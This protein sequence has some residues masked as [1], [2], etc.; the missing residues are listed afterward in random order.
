MKTFKQ[1]LFF[2]FIFLWSQSVFSLMDNHESLEK[3]LEQSL[4]VNWGVDRQ[5]N[6]FIRNKFKPLLKDASHHA[7]IKNFIFLSKKQNIIFPADKEIRALQPEDGIFK[8]TQEHK[9]VFENPYVR[10]LLGSTEPGARENFHT[11]VWK[12][13]MVVIIPTTYEIEY[14]DGK[15]EKIVYPIGV[16]E[17]PAG[18]CY[19]CTNLGNKAD[20]S[21]RFEIKD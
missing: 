8:A 18:E 19:A 15:K 7:I 12:S 6:A 3:E 14:P 20:A 2:M 21:L 4:H 5:T 13:I 10:I 1:F 16:F 11:H 9:V 17:L